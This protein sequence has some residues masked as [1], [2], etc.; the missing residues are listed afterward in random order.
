MPDNLALCG[1]SERE[2]VWAFTSFRRFKA[3]AKFPVQLVSISKKRFERTLLAKF[4]DHCI[5]GDAAQSEG[6]CRLFHHYEHQRGYLG[7]RVAC[8]GIIRWRK[9]ASCCDVRE[10]MQFAGQ[11]RSCGRLIIVGRLGSYAAAALRPERLG[12]CLVC[13]DA[14]GAINTVLPVLRP[15]RINRRG[16][17]AE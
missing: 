17:L 11:R 7:R 3:L 14:R 15:G 5:V 1:T 2:S 10:R 8:G 12:N 16:P 6:A 4:I 13:H 9:A